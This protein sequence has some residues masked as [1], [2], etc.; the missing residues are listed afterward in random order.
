MRKNIRTFF[1]ENLAMDY[2]NAPGEDWNTIVQGICEELETRGILSSDESVK[3]QEREQKGNNLVINHLALPHC[4]TQRNQA[5]FCGVCAPCGG[6]S[7]GWN[8]CA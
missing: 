3:I 5:F 6:G 4:T 8:T 1:P 2:H 7:G